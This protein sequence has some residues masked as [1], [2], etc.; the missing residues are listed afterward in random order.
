MLTRGRPLPRL[1]QLKTYNTYPSSSK[2]S[3]RRRCR[4]LTLPTQVSA[5]VVS[6]PYLMTTLIFK[7]TASPR[8]LWL[9]ACDIS[10][11]RDDNHSALSSI[12]KACSSRRHIPAL[13]FKSADPIPISRP[14]LSRSR[15]S[16]RRPS[17]DA[18]AIRQ[19]GKD[20]WLTKHFTIGHLDGDQLIRRCADLLLKL[21][22]WNT[23]CPQASAPPRRTLAAALMQAE[24]ITGLYL[25]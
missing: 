8:P 16:L 25:V 14:D 3:R 18:D 22:T 9:A 1:A 23:A 13:T 12:H 10:N 4:L 7:V 15:C 2:R 21:S 20:R 17:H 19:G 11:S 6:P 24:E 5:P